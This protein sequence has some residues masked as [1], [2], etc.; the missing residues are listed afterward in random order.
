MQSNYMLE[1]LGN[2]L[3]TYMSLWE[4]DEEV[5]KYYSEKKTISNYNGKI[6]IPKEFILDVDGQNPRMAQN[7]AIGNVVTSS[8][9]L[10][11]NKVRDFASEA[12]KK[13]SEKVQRTF[14]SKIKERDEATENAIKEL[15]KTA[16]EF[17][18]ENADLIEVKEEFEKDVEYLFKSL[19][20]G[21]EHFEGDAKAVGI[22]Q[23]LAL[24]TSHYRDWLE[25]TSFKPEHEGT[26]KEMIRKLEDFELVG[27]KIWN[28]NTEK[29]QE[30]L[31]RKDEKSEALMFLASNFGRMFPEPYG[32]NNSRKRMNLLLI[33][34]SLISAS[35][36]S[37]GSISSSVR[38]D[39]AKL[40][41][42]F[43]KSS[44]FSS[45]SIN[46]AAIGCPP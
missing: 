11:P 30:F 24:S 9:D 32:P 27:E 35:S 21:K 41:N 25:N 8:K 2:K 1:L 18:K 6:Y 31:N 23:Q 17:E 12:G 20:K 44:K 16:N 46:P 29:F 38:F 26:V 28:S 14:E 39:S 5:K 33:S 36:F 7:K 15:N 45:D 43:L 10:I 3:D 40:R 37:L 42:A 4:Y 22:S 34:L 19:N 13:M